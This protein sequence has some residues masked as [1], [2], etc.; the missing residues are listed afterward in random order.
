MGDKVKE[1][2]GRYNRRV[3]VSEFIEACA[4]NGIYTAFRSMGMSGVK[5][6]DLHNQ[7]YT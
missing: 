2:L 1:L 4:K 5:M 3:T 7:K 6:V